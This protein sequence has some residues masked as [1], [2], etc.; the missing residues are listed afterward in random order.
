MDMTVIVLIDVILIYSRSKNK[1]ENHLR[2]VFQA[3]NDHQ[4]FSKFNKCE[5]WLKLV[6][7][8]GHIVPGEGI[9]VD[10]QKIKIVKN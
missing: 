8:I 5:F 7:L 4:L 1:H 2:M 9:Q 6:A 10:A 3:L